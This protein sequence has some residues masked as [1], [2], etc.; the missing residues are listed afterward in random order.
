MRFLSMITF[1][2]N[3]T[4]NTNNAMNM[5]EAAIAPYVSKMNA[6]IHYRKNKRTI[7]NK[8]NEEWIS[9]RR[10][11]E[12]LWP[13]LSK[14]AKKHYNAKKDA[15]HKT[16]N[17]AYS[18]AWYAGKAVTSYVKA[19]LTAVGNEIC[20]FYLG[21]V[22]PK[23]CEKIKTAL[24]SYLVPIFGEDGYSVTRSPDKELCIYAKIETCFGDYVSCD[25]TLSVENPF[26]EVVKPKLKT[27]DDIEELLKQNEAFEQEFEKLQAETK[28]K[29]FAIYEKYPLVYDC[30]LHT[31]KNIVLE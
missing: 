30:A 1:K 7:A 28:E 21:K 16:Y 17:D 5:T 24:S 11:M 10:E 29:I 3:T 8:A 15:A 22:G 20:P 26:G 13:S 4:M 31:V 19:I 9:T 23:T 2:H 27:P 25:S 18:K 14:E 6:L 12:S